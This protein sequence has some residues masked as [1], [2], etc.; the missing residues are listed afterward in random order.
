MRLGKCSLTHA[1]LAVATLGIA[2][3]AAGNAAATTVSYTFSQGGW[4]DASGD[5]GT[6]TGTF[7]GTAQ[8]NG[9]LQLPNLTSFQASFHETGPKG[10]NTFIFNLPNTTDFLYDPNSAFLDFASGSAASGI[11]LCSGGPDTNAV[12]FGINPN[13]GAATPFSGFFDD[14]P[15]F[16]Q[17]TTRMGSTVTPAGSAAPEPENVGLLAAAGVLFLGLGVSRKLRFAHQ[18]RFTRTARR[19]WD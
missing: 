7:A 14:L 10:M 18:R 12:C 17:T 13:S 1:P 2:C 6:L 5:T 11:Q 16:G 3:F 9:E 4:S 15:L 8:P 19:S